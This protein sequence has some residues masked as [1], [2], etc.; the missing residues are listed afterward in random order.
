MNLLAWPGL[1]PALLVRDGESE[2]P[3]PLNAVHATYFF[4]AR[5]AIYHLFRC[6]GLGPDAPVLVP[7]YHSG[8][9]IEAIRAAGASLRFYGIDRQ[10]EPDLDEIVRL[11]RQEPRPRVLFCIHFLGWPQP[12]EALTKICREYDLIL[13]EDC[14]LAMLSEREGRP[15]GSFGDYAVFCMYKTVPIPNGGLLVQNEHV[16]EAL[17]SMKMKPGSL[18]SVNGRLCDLLLARRNGSNHLRDAAMAFKQGISKR[19]SAFGVPRTPIGEIGFDINRVDLAMSKVSRRL[20]RTFD[21][22]NIRRRRRE[23]FLQ[24]QSSLQGR[25]AFIEKPLQEGVCPLFFPLLVAD[26]T[27]A[28]KALQDCGIGTIE[29]WNTTPAG[30]NEG[31]DVAFLRR[32][33]LELPIH[34]DVT[35]EQISYMAEKVLNLGLGWSGPTL[36]N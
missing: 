25:A 35:S 23:N 28:A 32:H 27:S 8:N 36:D 18:I 24:L 3:F 34:Q 17:E 30:P 11:C 10:L 7:S 15:L 2:A 9:E 16:I 26:K 19:L 33:V 14:A 1:D 22:D 20:L 6:L 12:I 21:Y 4:R 5:N 13:V 29:F 31:G